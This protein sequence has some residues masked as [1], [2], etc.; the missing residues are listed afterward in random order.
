MTYIIHG[1]AS[2][3]ILP[4]VMDSWHHLTLEILPC[5]MASQHRLVRPG[6]PN[7]LRST[8]GPKGQKTTTVKHKK[9]LKHSKEVNQCAVDS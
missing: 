5:F 4:Y 1:P 6:A 2:G 3:E 8:I 7:F 9:W